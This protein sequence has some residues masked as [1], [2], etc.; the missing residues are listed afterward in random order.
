[1][2]PVASTAE[3]EECRRM[4]AAPASNKKMESLCDPTKWL[5]LH[6]W[7]VMAVLYRTGAGP[8]FTFSPLLSITL[9]VH[10]AQEVSS[11]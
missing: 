11:G 3:E 4:T 8:W 7:Q 1:M 6:H 2:G 5:V 10:Y 9:G